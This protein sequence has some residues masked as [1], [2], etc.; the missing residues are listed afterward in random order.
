MEPVV[1]VENVSVR[2]AM[3]GERYATFNEYAI[4][5]LQGRVNHRSLWAVRG[6]TFQVEQGDVFALIGRNG[7]GKST[8]LKVIARVLR[9]TSGR[10]R[11]IGKIAPLLEFG[12]G[13]HPELT[14]REN[15]FL[16]GTLLGFSNH[17]MEEKL[18]RIVD[19]AE[20]REFIDSPLRTYSSGMAAR[21]GFSIATDVEPEVLIVDEALA[22]G[23]E[24]FQRKCEDR[25][26]GFRDRGATVLLVTHA[27][28][29]VRSI[30]NR[31]VWIDKG[32]LRAVG[33]ADEVVAQFEQSLESG[34]APSPGHPMAG[35]TTA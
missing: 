13:F 17:E 5:R 22:V 30:C 3:P 35:E 16:N 24:G 9:P 28:R 29:T 2:F 18:E 1:Q 11:I 21:L 25:M 4:R 26:R 15:V 34:Q 32:E 7:A 27:M 19:F 20:L 31:A 6:L 10:V 8:L 33:A 14:G 12:A 23:D